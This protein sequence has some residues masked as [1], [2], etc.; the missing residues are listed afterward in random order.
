VSERYIDSIMHGATIKVIVSVVSCWIETVYLQLC[1]FETFLQSTY[2]YAYSKT[3]IERYS[4]TYNMLPLF[5]SRWGIRINRLV[6]V[7]RCNG[8]NHIDGCPYL[9]RY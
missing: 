9:R 2:M 3:R 8:K 6:Y 1:H 5:M 4:V 7:W